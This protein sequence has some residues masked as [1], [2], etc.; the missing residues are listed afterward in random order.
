M[1]IPAIGDYDIFILHN[2]RNVDPVTMKPNKSVLVAW[3]RKYTNTMPNEVQQ[4]H[5]SA[6]ETSS[7]V[8]QPIA[9][10]N[11]IVIYMKANLE[12]ENLETKTR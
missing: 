7:I 3:R 2:A 11:E 4:I 9:R 1:T 8:L 5:I 10:S 6:I 12:N